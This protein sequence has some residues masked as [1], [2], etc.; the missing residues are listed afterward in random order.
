[1]TNFITRHPSRFQESA[2]LA[3]VGD[4]LE[5]CI[6][7]GGRRT[8]TSALIQAVRSLTAWHVHRSPARPEL[9][10]QRARKTAFIQRPC[11]VC[12]VNGSS[13]HSSCSHAA[14]AVLDRWVRWCSITIYD[15]LLMR[16]PRKPQT[17]TRNSAIADWPSINGN[18][19]DSYNNRCHGPLPF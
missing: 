10:Q 16:C 13:V 15:P 5:H 12:L 4:I 8:R 1:V 9:T 7:Q 19:H 14:I 6:H 11:Q 18:A 3:A 2:V 17:L